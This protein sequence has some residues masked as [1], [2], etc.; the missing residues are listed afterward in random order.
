MYY[1]QLYACI[2]NIQYNKYTSGRMTITKVLYLYYK[3]YNIINYYSIN[4]LNLR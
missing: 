2:R 3:L 1:I 4:V